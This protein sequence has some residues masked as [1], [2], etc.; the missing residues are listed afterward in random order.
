MKT[1]S[2]KSYI[3]SSMQQRILFNSFASEQQE[4]SI[5]QMVW[6]LHED[7]KVVAFRQ[8]WQKII[9][10]NPILRTSFNWSDSSEPIQTVHPQVILRINEQDWSQLL[11][12]KQ[13]KRQQQY[14][15]LDRQQHFDLNQAPLMRLAVIKLGEKKYQIIW[16]F[17]RIL[18]DRDSIP[19][20]LKQVF[21][22]YKNNEQPLASL[23]PFQNYI[24]WLKQQDIFL[25]EK[26][27]REKLKG[28]TA[29]TPLI[30]EAELNKKI[31]SQVE[32]G[33]ESIYLSNTLSLELSSLVK[34]HKLSLKILL[35]GVWSLLLS[36]Y[37]REEDV[38]FFGLKSCRYWHPQG[39]SMV[40][41]FTNLLP[42]R[43]NI[44]RDIPAIVWLKQLREESINSYPH[45]PLTKILE[46]SEV[47][48][49]IDLAESLVIFE[50]ASLNSTMHSLGNEWKN[51]DIQL[52]QQSDFPLTVLGYGG[53]EI[54][55]KIEYDRQRFDKSTITRMLG[56]LQVLL[57]GVAT[58]PEQ[59][60]SKLPLLTKAEEFQLLVEWN[61]TQTNYPRNRCIHYLFEA[62]VEQTPDEIA[63][64]FEQQKLTYRELNER[65]N[66]LAHYLQKIGIQP[67]TLVGMCVERSFEMIVT[68]LGILKA[69]GAY[70]PLDP[71]Y[72]Q[73]RLEYMLSH[74]QISV[75][76]A[77]QKWLQV[78]PNHSASVICWE[79]ER[80]VI[81]QESKENPI[82]Q[83]IP[84]NLAYVMYTS[85]STGI[86]KGV[87]V[88]H[89]GVVR[90][91]K[92]TNYIDISPEQTFLQLAPISFDASTLEIWA[93]LLNGGKLVIFP[94]RIPSL[95][96]LGK[97]IQDYQVT[98]LWLTAG[99]FHLM[100]DERLEDLKPLRQLLAGGDVLSIPHV[101]KCLETLPNLK[102]I[103]G[104]GPTENTTFTCCYTLTDP[105]QIDRS[106]PI[107]K[108][109]ANTQ[110]YIL[111]SHL[112][113]VPIGV[114]GELYIGG[115]GL[116]R[117]YLHRSE[118][119]KE[120]FI[121]NPFT[122]DSDSRLYKSGDLVRYLSD[123]NIEF[124]GRIDNQVKIR[125]FRIE[126]GEIET[127]LSQ[128]P[129]VRQAA[130]IVR[131]DEPGNKALV[132]YVV[133]EETEE[134]SIADL[135]EF[136]KEK[137]PSLREF[138]RDKLPS[139]MIPSAFV[140]LE[141]FPLNPNGKVDRRALPAPDRQKLLLERVYTP[142]QNE[143]ETT[144]VNIWSKLLKLERVSREDN[145]FD[146]G[147]N[148]LLSLQM[149]VQLQQQLK[150]DLPIVKLFQYPTISSL[151]KYLS[152][153][154]KSQPQYQKLR[155]R[156]QQPTQLS[157]GIA[158]IGMV[159]RFPGANNVD[160]LWQNLCNGVASTTFFKEE[161]LDQSIDPELKQ[162]PNY[163]KAK[164]I[165]ENAD[166]FDAA[167]FNI[168]P[169]E[170]EVMDPQQRIFLEVAH[171]ALENTG[172]D[173]ERFDG[174]IGLYGGSGN[175]TYFAS[176]ICGRPEVTEGIGEFQTMLAND[177]DF[178]T[179]RVSY[180]LNLKGPSISVNTACSTSL[181]A[182]CQAFNSLINNQCDMALAG[183]ISISTPLKSG[184][185][186]QEGSM[187][188]PDGYCRPFDA[189][190][191]GT[192]FNNGVGIV[193]LKRLEDAIQ[194]GDRIEAVIRGVGMN[195]DGS[196]KV[197]FTA[198]SVD[199]QA[200]AVAMAHAS[201]GVN[202]ETISYVETHG[203]ATPLGDPIEMTALTQAFRSQTSAT[204]FCAVGS[205][206]SNVGHLVCAA[207]VTGV[208][209]TALALK[210]K[211]IP[212]SLHFENPNPDIEFAK[213]PFYVN[214]QLSEWKTEQTPRRA[215]VSSFGVGGTNA[216]IVL[217]EP[218]T[219]EPSGN[220]RPRQLLLVSA[221]T[222]SALETA[223]TELGNYLNH[224]PEA[225][226]ADVAYTLQVGRK[227]FSH[228]RFAVSK[229]LKDG[230]EIL[231][232]LPPKL[233]AT[234]QTKSQSAEIIFMFPGQG[235]QYVNMGLNL[236][237]SEPVFR[238]TVDSC[239][240]IL[241][242]HLGQDLRKF[243]YPQPG[244][245]ETAAA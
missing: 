29:P 180:K 234:R 166:L 126:L 81:S 87:S 226:L 120:K 49:G 188:S 214:A 93:P 31:Y 236:Y 223:T 9:D 22:Y 162:N 237:E 33:E 46:W 34:K 28:F 117:G 72:P 139:Y 108:A 144:L 182:I 191:R 165:I 145:F 138:L 201:A 241:Q 94:P 30:E 136:L 86:P 23:P 228:R 204:G 213:S 208:M 134:N 5:N 113:P 151:A 123:G 45:T 159:G 83:T 224:Q 90:L 27:W 170:A 15:K 206:K 176:N 207:G 185:L 104:Y 124:L 141:A 36:R 196:G 129:K 183:G 73:E 232:S 59:N 147:G 243:L 169:R 4:I 142:P 150:I 13:K 217:E 177:K 52:L 148:S 61:K 216:H 41:I 215:G 55:I 240:E 130:V 82:S 26:F 63:V 44:S 219:V 239:A 80:E 244:D 42:V 179:T 163:V 242:P 77:Q 92:E 156:V 84:T 158:I 173:P 20:I 210:H 184:Y 122:K 95:M 115:D 199:G 189:R 168:S 37:S 60:L 68:I 76:I 25:A 65:A 110:V 112:Q 103:N 17:H 235:S 101:R 132:A 127:A 32:R 96:E 48:R 128:H 16:S 2:L 50:D 121:P 118:I 119:T 19:I 230:V 190:A 178:L 209:K 107:G 64:V 53:E 106:I 225:N 149:M 231:K 24:E 40:G 160:E 70:L 205:V 202:P 62:Q 146:L 211:L 233:T 54:L 98:T 192:M 75:L 186:Y 143:L 198:P 137:L 171:E 197:S 35:Q 157:Q 203:T 47:P 109:I 18:L 6:T 153:G 71:D 212:P 220:S 164:G 43:V 102:L 172:Y 67:D 131:E 154:Q 174:L 58:H 200:E 85:G 167:F 57:A 39:G 194:D 7:L 125:G 56:H 238:E 89:R 245:I 10:Q 195:N 221:K 161:E 14:L 193:V 21:T 3:L 88:V 66:Q 100:V 12:E 91:V 116:A 97:A 74:S 229:N 135:Q 51:Q 187:L 175:N 8:A 78:L 222:K 105:N 11:E 111:D 181:V 133:L 218:P 1:N 140:L 155:E 114:P 99:L 79:T 69:G 38:V 227:G 152:Q